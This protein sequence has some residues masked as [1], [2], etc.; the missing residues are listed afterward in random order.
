MA[1]QAQRKTLNEIAQLTG[2]SR[3]TIY[4]V[5]NGKGTVAEK[6]RGQVLR[7]LEQYDYRPNINARNLARNRL[8]TI[9][10]AGL[11]AKNA[12]YFSELIMRGIDKALT[13]LEDHG[14]RVISRIADLEDP[15]QQ[16]DHVSDLVKLG[17]DALL[18]IPDDPAVVQPVVDDL[19]IPV[20]LLSRY[21]PAE[22][23]RFPYVGCDYRG[24]GRIAGDLL[25]RML[26]PG[27]KV[28]IHSHE[29]LHEDHYARERLRGALEA[30]ER[31]GHVEVISE[32]P[33][34]AR[35][36][37]DLR[38]RVREILEDQNGAVRGILDITGDPVTISEAIKDMKLVEPV[39]FVCFDLFPEIVDHLKEGFVD[40]IVF[41]DLP[42]QARVAVT[43]LFHEVCFGL[44]P[45]QLI[46]HCRL[47]IIMRENIG[48][49]LN[50]ELQEPER[51]L[52]LLMNA[53]SPGGSESLGSEEGCG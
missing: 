20:C 35:S 15:L 2:I 14:L 21:F 49:F 52:P 36:G 8:Y 1:G 13:Q 24:S 19:D 7:A 37:E 46:T 47:D 9:G 6:T 40:A 43:A 44:K 17:V 45:S 16:V 50:G 48:Y 11:Q 41:Q 3:Y 53:G 18:I 31:S 42:E 27:E 51:S 5:I 25:S 33:D 4:K 23:Q 12:P 26:R 32:V 38:R 29:L 28:L 34:F 30:I 22:P 39:R 10:F